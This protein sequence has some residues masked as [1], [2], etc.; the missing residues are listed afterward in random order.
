MNIRNW[1]GLA[2]IIGAG[3]INLICANLFL[4]LIN[5]ESIT[6]DLAA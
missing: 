3:D 4:E 2:L 1:E 5:N 6:S